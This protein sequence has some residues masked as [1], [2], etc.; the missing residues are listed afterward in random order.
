MGA[1]TPKSDSGSILSLDN[2]PF[3]P[4]QQK[5]QQQKAI[6]AYKGDLKTAFYDN[7]MR[8]LDDKRAIMH[9]VVINNQTPTR[10]QELLQLAKDSKLPAPTMTV[11][12]PARRGAT[13]NLLNA[14]PFF[15]KHSL[16]ILNKEERD[17]WAER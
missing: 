4:N 6:E 11:V 1:H 17:Q 5:A 16:T 13:L 10:L 14:V 7:Q 3:D 9:N 15:H 2:K 8:R 12:L